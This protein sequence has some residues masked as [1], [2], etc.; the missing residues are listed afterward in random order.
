MYNEQFKDDQKDFL[1]RQENYLVANLLDFFRNPENEDKWLKAAKMAISLFQRSQI[2][3]PRLDKRVFFLANQL[4]N[5]ISA[6]SLRLF[7]EECLKSTHKI[8]RGQDFDQ[9]GSK[10]KP[11]NLQRKALKDIKVSLETGHSEQAALTRAAYSLAKE[12]R[13][14]EQKERQQLLIKNHPLREIFEVHSNNKALPREDIRN[15]LL[16]LKN[17]TSHNNPGQGVLFGILKKAQAFSL[18]RIHNL[19]GDELFF[20]CRPLG[21]VDKN[22]QIIEVEVPSSAHMNALTYRKLEI[23]KALKADPTFKRAQN[24][25]LKVR[26]RSF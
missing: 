13:A 4:K 14:E 26:S 17:Y 6:A 22:E 24:I 16:N 18:Y 9:E 21:F 5:N 1:K 15:K 23:L 10:K 8:P 11:I 25:K 3:S 12:K 19:L 7:A 20:L 2:S